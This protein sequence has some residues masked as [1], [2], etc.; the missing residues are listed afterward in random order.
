MWGMSLAIRIIQERYSFDVSARTLAGARLNASAYLYHS[1]SA[2]D[3]RIIRQLR[4]CAVIRSRCCAPV[5]DGA[6]VSADADPAPIRFAAA[7]R[8]RRLTWVDARSAARA[9]G[10]PPPA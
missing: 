2:W 6:A 10:A 9:A 7:T 8:A 5:A 4:R 3:C 1:R